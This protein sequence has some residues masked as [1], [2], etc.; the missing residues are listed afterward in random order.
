MFLQAI[1]QQQ[2]TSIELKYANRIDKRKASLK[3]RDIPENRKKSRTGKSNID[4]ND[5][6]DGKKRQREKKNKID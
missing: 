1:K 3:I 6:R 2:R 4:L 5:V